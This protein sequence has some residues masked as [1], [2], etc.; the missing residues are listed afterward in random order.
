MFGSFR[1]V[2]INPYYLVDS[3]KIVFT[4]PQ[5][6]QNGP[7]ADSQMVIDKVFQKM[8]HYRNFMT[9]MDHLFTEPFRVKEPP[10]NNLQKD[11]VLSQK[12]DS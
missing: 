4:G 7:L 2:V 3:S 8:K 9:F 1:A 11:W 10:V 12:G 5:N 6:V